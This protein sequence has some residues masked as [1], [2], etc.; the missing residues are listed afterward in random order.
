MAPES[1]AAASRGKGS[2]APRRVEAAT[3][4]SVG[5]EHGVMSA[6]AALV[7]FLPAEAL[8]LPQSFWGAI[9]AIAV[10]QSEYKAARSTARDQFVG[11]AIGGAPH[12]S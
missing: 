9:T 7:A 10:V 4:R 5:L 11:A 8:G 1:D 3:V 6:I 12:W 2:E